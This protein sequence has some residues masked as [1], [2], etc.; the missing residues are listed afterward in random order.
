MSSCIPHC[1]IRAHLC[2]LCNDSLMSDINDS[3]ENRLLETGLLYVFT[4][5]YIYIYIYIYVKVK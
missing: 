1:I 5:I 2:Y 3:P 4:Y